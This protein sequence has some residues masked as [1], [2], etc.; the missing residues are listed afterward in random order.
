MDVRVD[1][2]VFRARLCEIMYSDVYGGLAIL[3]DVGARESECFE[4]ILI[5]GKGLPVSDY[6]LT[7][8]KMA[9]AGF[10]HHPLSESRDNVLCPYCRISLDSWDRADDPVAEHR[11]TRANCVH[12]HYLDINSKK[13]PNPHSKSR[14]IKRKLPAKKPAASRKSKPPAALQERSENPQV[15]TTPTVES[16]L[17]EEIIRAKNAFIKQRA[18]TWKDMEKEFLDSLR[19]L[20]GA[21]LIR[22]GLSQN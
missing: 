14:P 10:I 15:P 13:G 3:R 8:F 7:P 21:P 4:G 9:Q 22:G 17:K 18:K 20:R 16:F 5:S 2:G 11:K 1:T 6:E 12:M 19:S